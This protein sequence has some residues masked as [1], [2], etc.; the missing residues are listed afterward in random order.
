MNNELWYAT[1]KK[2]NHMELIDIALSAAAIISVITLFKSM[3]EFVKLEARLKQTK[4]FFREEIDSG[5]SNLHFAK[6]ELRRDISYLRED[7]NLMR[8]TL[9]QEIEATRLD[10]LLVKEEMGQIDF[11]LESISSQICFF[12]DDL[13]E[14]FDKLK[15]ET[16]DIKQRISFLE[17]LFSCE[18]F[19]EN[20]RSD[21]AKRMWQRRKT[22]K[23]EH[24]QED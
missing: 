18:E 24:K 20:T 1:R 15:S 6:E 3:R 16:S 8:G 23:I 2:E 17:A 7:L 19:V 9:K 4:E 14:Q 10:I 12:R 22:K 21:G 11:E 13:L 5:R